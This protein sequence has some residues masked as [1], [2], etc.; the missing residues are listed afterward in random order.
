M[1][2]HNGKIVPTGFKKCPEC[3]KLY[4]GPVKKGPRH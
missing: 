2:G 4:G 3:T 1:A